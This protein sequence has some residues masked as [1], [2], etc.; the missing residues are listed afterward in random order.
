MDSKITVENSQSS[1]PLPPSQGLPRWFPTNVDWG[2]GAE[3]P[4][5]PMEK[6][7]GETQ[8]ALLQPQ[9]RGGFPPVLSCH[10]P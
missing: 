3:Q 9:G 2:V 4:Q 6:G 8:G 7:N 10:L 5:K 1:D